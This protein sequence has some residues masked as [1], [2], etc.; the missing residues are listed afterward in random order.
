VQVLLPCNDA[1]CCFCCNSL[2]LAQGPMLQ[3][4]LF[5]AAAL[6]VSRPCIRSTMMQLLRQSTPGSRCY[7]ASISS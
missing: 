2:H 6:K 4:Y 5:L 7:T 3:A 1:L